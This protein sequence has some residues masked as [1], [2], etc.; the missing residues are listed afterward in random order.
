MRI[1]KGG[2][3]LQLCKSE[4]IRDV[5]V[6]PTTIAVLCIAVRSRANNRGIFL[7]DTEILGGAI[8]VYEHL[9]IRM[10]K[11]ELLSELDPFLIGHFGTPIIEWET[12][13]YFP[14][15]YL[16]M[17][18]YVSKNVYDNYFLE[19]HLECSRSK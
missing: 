18:N 10:E 4:L 7:T 14:D 5:E 13:H 19:P 3:L 9:K 15:D 12:L 17:L 6:V 1:L 8:I 2:G 11:V 16:G